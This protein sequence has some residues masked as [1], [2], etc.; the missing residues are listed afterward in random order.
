MAEIRTRRN[1]INPDSKDDTIK[2]PLLVIPSVIWQNMCTAKIPDE[3][4]ANLTMLGQGEVAYLRRGKE[5]PMICRCQSWGFRICW[6]S[7]GVV[8]HHSKRCPEGFQ[9]GCSWT[10]TLFVRMTKFCPTIAE[11]DPFVPVAT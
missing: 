7:G 6:S 9:T 3:S 4:L 11:L 5:Q 10:V 2:S 8:D 1:T